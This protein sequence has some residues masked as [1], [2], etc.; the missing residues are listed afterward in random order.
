MRK[1]KQSEMAKFEFLAAATSFFMWLVSTMQIF[2]LT[3]LTWF[4]FF[5]GYF[6]GFFFTVDGLRRYRAG[7]FVI[8][9]V[10]FMILIYTI[11]WMFLHAL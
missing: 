7:G 2:Y 1:P 11:F 6:G 10:V 5:F 4:V 3:S 8:G 9:G